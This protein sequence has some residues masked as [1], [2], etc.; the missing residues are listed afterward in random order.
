MEQEKKLPVVGLDAA[1]NAIN[2]LTSFYYYVD[3][4]SEVVDELRPLI[5]SMKES[6][7]NRTG[8]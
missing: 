5:V 4:P 2:Y 7:L 6:I 3:L 1:I 8:I